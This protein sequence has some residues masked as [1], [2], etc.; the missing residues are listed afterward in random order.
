[1]SRKNLVTPQL[2]T[3][4]MRI[5]HDDPKL[6]NVY[7][8]S[9]AVPAQAGTLQKRLTD[10]KIKAKIYAKSGYLR[11]TIT[12]SGYMIYPDRTLT[13]SILLNDYKRPV[14]LGKKLIDDI[15]KATDKYYI[16]RIQQKEVLGG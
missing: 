7:I 14:Y 16:D 1:M 6:A 5:M 13:F 10:K 12:L 4:V 3:A 11:Q 15:V 9:F 8:N 2:L